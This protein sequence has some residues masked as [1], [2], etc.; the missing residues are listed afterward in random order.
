MR[1]LKSIP[2]IITASP[3]D[4]YAWRLGSKVPVKV[5]DLK[6]SAEEKGK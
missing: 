5:A 1:P 6:K 2:C 3:A 4:A